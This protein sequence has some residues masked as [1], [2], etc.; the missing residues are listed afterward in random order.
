MSA[1]PVAG[2]VEKPKKKNRMFARKKAEPPNPVT[3]T[4]FIRRALKDAS[5]TLQ[6]DPYLKKRLSQ[7]EAKGN[8][9][10]AQGRIDYSIAKAVDFSLRNREPNDRVRARSV[11]CVSAA[12][13]IKRTARCIII[14]E[15]FG[16]EFREVIDLEL[17][18]T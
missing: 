18:E 17:P 10:R 5:Q 14:V 16:H 9:K 8:L 6:G 2:T 12:D 4:I 11:T 13:L 3:L 15:A 7:L 1:S